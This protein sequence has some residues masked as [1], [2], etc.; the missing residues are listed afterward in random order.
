ML[1]LSAAALYG[2]GD[3]S[4]PAPQAQRIVIRTGSPKGKPIS[5]QKPPRPHHLDV[6]SRAQERTARSAP[7]V[8][9]VRGDP[10]K[11]PAA[12]A[13][14]NGSFAPP[15]G[16]ARKSM[17]AHTMAGVGNLP[18]SRS[19]ILLHGVALAPPERPRRCQ[20]SDQRRQQDR[21]HAPTSGAAGTRP[22]TPAATTARARSATRSAGGGFLSAP[23]ASSQLE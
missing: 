22:G 2:C 8:K 19:A 16:G 20:A 7:K 17:N 18:A 21:R 4:A 14:T 5:E 11:M 23:L 6:A 15:A 12:S 3:A 13:G 10:S 9:F 1:A